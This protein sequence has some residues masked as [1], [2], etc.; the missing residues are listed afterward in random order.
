[1]SLKNRKDFSLEFHLNLSLRIFV[2]IILGFLHLYINLN[3]IY[4]L[5]FTSFCIGFFFIR[6]IVVILIYIFILR[7]LSDK[8]VQKWWKL[9]SSP[10]GMGNL[11]ILCLLFY[12]L[13]GIRERDL[14]IEGQA[15]ENFAQTFGHYLFHFCVLFL[16]WVLKGKSLSSVNFIQELSDQL[17][18]LLPV[19]SSRICYINI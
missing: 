14:L 2:I 6:F 1:M 18:S 19:Q 9:C 17:E 3:D 10:L 13:N 4:D 7:Y 8:F 12:D 5:F 16:S 11:S 15:F